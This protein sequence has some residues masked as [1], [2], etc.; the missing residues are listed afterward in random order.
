VPPGLQWFEHEPEWQALATARL[1]QGLTDFHLTLRYADTLNVGAG[2]AAK[3]E[4]LGFSLGGK[5]ETFEEEVWSV[6]G[7]FSK[8][9]FFGW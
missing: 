7:T 2:V 3:I 9:G 4:G 6:T 1:E 8:K 5:Y